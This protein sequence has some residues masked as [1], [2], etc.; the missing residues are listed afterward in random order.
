MFITCSTLDPSPGTLNI[1]V[2]EI[3]TVVILKWGHNRFS[4]QLSYHL[5]A[6]EELSNSFVTRADL[7]CKTALIFRSVIV[8]LV[9]YLDDELDDYFECS[10]GNCNTSFWIDEHFDLKSKR[11]MPV[12]VKNI[13]W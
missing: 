6:S 1:Y 3:E 9:K 11:R 13:L 10:N 5:D 12:S 7:S 2:K 8:P 4:M